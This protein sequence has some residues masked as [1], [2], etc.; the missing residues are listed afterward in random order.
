MLEVL[1]LELLLLLGELID[2]VLGVL[3]SHVAVGDQLSGVRDFL[4]LAVELALDVFDALVLV[5]EEAL[6]LFL[7]MVEFVTLI[8]VLC[9]EV[10]SFKLL[11]LGFQLG[12]KDF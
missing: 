9:H 5:M 10:V 1:V 8:C 12:D 3:E 6:V 2:L 11:V 4:D 7:L